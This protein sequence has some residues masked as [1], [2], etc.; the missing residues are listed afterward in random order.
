[1]TTDQG[2]QFE[3]QLFK[4]IEKL[5]GFTRIRTTAYHPQ[6]NGMVERFHRHLK[7]ALMCHNDKTWID[8]LPVVLLGIRTA[9]KEDLKSTTAE[10]LYGQPLRLPAEML[11]AEQSADKVEPEDY[12]SQLRRAMEG[13]RPSPV[14]ENGIARPFMFKGMKEATHV[15]I[16]RG[17]LRRALQTP[18]EGPYE[19]IERGDNTI[20]VLIN[21]KRSTVSMERVKPVFGAN[22]QEKP[23]EANP[24]PAAV[25]TRTRAG[26]AIKP[27][28]RFSL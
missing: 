5:A 10:M 18:Y 19:V 27:R 25:Q 24:Q 3:S 23:Y 13:T 11:A 14:K 6:A 16:R 20:V 17:I 28:V 4:R 1:M 26:R 12:A 2:R 15:F 8:A 9:W 22:S 21:G 7:A